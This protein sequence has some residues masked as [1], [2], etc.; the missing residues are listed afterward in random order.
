MNSGWWTSGSRRLSDAGCW[1]LG[2]A[3]EINHDSLPTI[4]YSPSASSARPIV[5]PGHLDLRIAE[6][7]T[8]IASLR[9][10]FHR[11]LWIQSGV[12][13]GGVGVIVAL[14]EALG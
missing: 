3:A 12:I 8:E 6:V 10:E 13:I 1:L 2:G 14:V 9:G 5:T 7:R 4:H 11:A